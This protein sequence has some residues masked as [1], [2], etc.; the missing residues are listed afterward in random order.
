MEI[1]EPPELSELDALKKEVGQ[2]FFDYGAAMY[3]VEVAEKKKAELSIRLHNL[4][5]RA[6]KLQQKLHKEAQKEAMKVKL[7]PG[8]VTDPDYADP[9]YGGPTQ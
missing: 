9:V 2:C 4:N 7:S 5:E 6:V 3:E 8:P 1:V